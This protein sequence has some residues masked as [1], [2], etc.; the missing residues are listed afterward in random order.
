MV[1]FI[2]SVSADVG[3]DD[4]QDI[5]TDIPKLAGKY[6]APIDSIRSIVRPKKATSKNSDECVFELEKSNTGPLESRAHAFMRMIGFPVAVKPDKF[7]NP[8]HD[9]TASLDRKRRRDINDAFAT[10]DAKKMLDKREDNTDTRISIF[11]R[12]DLNAS[13]YT[14]LLTSGLVR[15]FQILKDGTGPLDKDKQEDHVKF[16]D[17]TVDQFFNRN[18]KRDV[19]E[20]TALTSVIDP[21]FTKVSHILRPFVVDPSVECTAMPIDNRMAVPFL[22]SKDDLKIKEN[23][24]VMRPG[25]ELILRERLRVSTNKDDIFLETAKQILDGTIGPNSVLRQRLTTTEGQ[26][27]VA[28]VEALLG[29]H[30]FESQKIDELKGIS[31][32]QTANIS[33]LV[34]VLKSI[35]KVL[36]ESTITVLCA[37]GLQGSDAINW[38]PIPNAQG[39]ELGLQGAILN[40]NKMS[41]RETEIDKKIINL[42]IK[43][44]NARTQKTAIANLGEF[45]SPFTV[46]VNDENTQLVDD[47]LNEAIQK[48]DKIAKDAF[49]AMGNIELKVGEISGLGLIDILSIYIAL[50]AMDEEAIISLLDNES[51]GRLERFFPD[52]LIGSTAAAARAVNG[53]PGVTIVEALEKF[54]KKLKNVF[55]FVDFE[56]A[57]QFSNR[58]KGGDIS[59]DN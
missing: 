52:I 53:T 22:Q 48:R 20:I 26:V 1:G 10:S 27:L 4:I 34:K 42:N 33:K 46:T 56:I 58:Q 45:A 54:E 3:G 5:E 38:V 24:S 21:T 32:V 16:R 6:I 40:R 59:P 2:P 11:K 49:V 29:E 17:Q 44:I 57:R 23:K 30:G 43:S 12:Q 37:V 41:T 19:S 51:F 13:V 39:P 28:T 14:L 35:I 55:A 31:E 47:S 9:P 25:L 8:G 7:Y 18:N 50:W 15:P 36:H